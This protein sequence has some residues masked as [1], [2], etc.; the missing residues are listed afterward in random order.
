MPSCERRK[1]IQNKKK[2]KTLM[3]GRTVSCVITI[4]YETYL[5]VQDY[6]AL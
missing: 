4:L 2:T 1:K 6:N 5:G 3:K